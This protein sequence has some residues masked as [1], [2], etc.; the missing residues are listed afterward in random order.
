[1]RSSDDIH[2]VDRLFH[3]IKRYRSRIMAFWIVSALLYALPSSLFASS[4]FDFTE[5]ERAYLAAKP[6]VRVGVHPIYRMPYWSGDID[7]PTGVLHD[8]SLLMGNSLDIPVEY[9]QFDSVAEVLAAVENNEVDMA[10]GY[11]KDPER[12]DVF[13]FSDAIFRVSRVAW[14]RGDI[15]NPDLSALEW[16]CV[17]GTSHC[18]YLLQKGYANVQE[19]RDNGEVYEALLVKRIDAVLD[20]YATGKRYIAENNMS[21]SAL[22]YDNDYGYINARMITSYHQPMLVDIFN[23]LLADWEQ[24]GALQSVYQKHDIGYDIYTRTFGGESCQQTL[25]YTISEDLFPFS[26]WDEK[27]QQYRGYVHDL[28]SRISARTPLNFEYVKPEGRNLEAMLTSG[29]VDFIPAYSANN[30]DSTRYLSTITYTDAA[31]S[32]IASVHSTSV[33]KVG[34]LDRRGILR[35]SRLTGNFAVYSDTQSLLDDLM[36]GD[37]SHAYVNSHLADSLMWSGYRDKI[38][39]I[40]TPSDPNL[41]TRLTMIVPPDREELLHLLNDAIGAF[42]PKELESIWGPYSRMAYKWGIDKRQVLLYTACIAILLAFLGMVVLKY[43]HKMKQKIETYY[44]SLL[45]TQGKIHWLREVI[46]AIPDMICIRDTDKSVLLTNKTYQALSELA[47]YQDQHTLSDYL[48]QGL[49][50]D[51]NSDF[52]MTIYV[53]EKGHALFGCYYQVINKVFE[54]ETD[55]GDFIMTMFNDVTA[56][57][58]KEQGLIESNK[59]ANALVQQKKQFVAIVSHELRTPISA[60]LG[61]MEILHSGYNKADRTLVLSNAIESANRLKDL[62]D[63][64][65]DY[66][67]LDAN[68]MSVHPEPTNLVLALCPLIRSF[69]PILA[70]KGLTLD[71]SWQPSAYIEA[72]IDIL[73]V[74]QIVSNILSNAI[75]FTD[76]GSITVRIS[77]SETT[78]N[79]SVRDTGIGMNDEQLAR[80]FEPFVQADVHIAR[81]FGGTGLGMSIVASLVSLMSGAIKATS[82]LELGTRIDVALPI[83]GRRVFGLALNPPQPAAHRVESQW[84]DALGVFDALKTDHA[85]LACNAL[86]AGYN[87]YPDMLPVFSTEPRLCTEQESFGIH[88]HV[89]VVDDEP[90]NRFLIHKQ[91]E[92]LGLSATIVSNGLEAITELE[93]PD[94]D[95]DL[96]LTDCHM[97]ELDGFELVGKIRAHCPKYGQIPVIFY[98]ADYSHS[99]V[100]RAKQL[101]VV[102]ILY[103]PYTLA[104]LHKKLQ[105]TLGHLAAPS[106]IAV[107]WHDMSN[108]H[109]VKEMAAVIVESFSLVLGELEQP[110]VDMKSIAH[111]VKGSAAVIKN[112]L[113]T[114]LCQK[115]EQTPSDRQLLLLLGGEIA[116]VI[117]Q[118][119]T[120]LAE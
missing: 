86:P 43:Y 101:D 9:V 105:Q 108:Q 77:S 104:S 28:L 82:M 83:E 38:K 4:H 78:L 98:T 19:Y 74:S 118:A 24:H 49:D 119:K 109:N 67:K 107:P 94:N 13:L 93:N 68:Q 89:L 85:T 72:D 69:E 51:L 110:D 5:Q 71:F 25:K 96:L 54:E 64:I 16:G 112:P 84:F 117:E 48:L 73:R 20:T 42:G 46:D 53:S 23:K 100:E 61:L 29:I 120:Y 87:Y 31:Y 10:I 58:L 92:S 3:Q 6:T 116:R 60:M 79:I 47:E 65:L 15:S 115:I 34:V 95:F 30:I 111:R 50:V 56:A 88:G 62:V 35:A 75:K 63:D 32:Y 1:M 21:L 39:I 27:E 97:P 76:E 11:N 59:V 103:K 12:E 52:S 41:N 33:F 66:S 36:D 7:L 44:A 17:K 70:Q 99:T 2:S 26:F 113:L 102:R 81:K 57:K 91:L 37:I 14:T 106:A 8:V 45:R 55:H 80:L 40:E 90:I 22:H 18:Q 114:E